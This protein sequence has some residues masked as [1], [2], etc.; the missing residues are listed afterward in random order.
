MLS[1]TWHSAALFHP[2][3]ICSVVS[4]GCA[5]PRPVLRVRDVPGTALFHL[6]DVELEEVVQPG[7][8]FLSAEV[9]MSACAL[10]NGCVEGL[11]LEDRT[12]ILPWRISMYGRVTGCFGCSE[13][14]KNMR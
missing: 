10:C 6:C 14:N 7:H 2:V 9:H 8:E 3:S 5:A 1:K 11:P 13:R 12:L 4:R